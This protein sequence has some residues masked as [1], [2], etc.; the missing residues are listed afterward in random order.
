MSSPAANT[1]RIEPSMTGRD[2]PFMV[3]SALEITQILHAIMRDGSLIT[4]TIDAND[5]FLTS[6]LAIDEA[7]N[8]MYL[9]R[10]RTRPRL[11]STLQ[12]RM[13]SYN[14]TLEKVQ[15]RFSSEGIETAEYDGEEAYKVPLPTEMLR[16]QR[17]EFYRVS[18]P[19]ANPV[20]CRLS[21]GKNAVDGAVELNICDISCGGIAVQSPPALFT[22]ELGAYYECVVLLPGTPG[23]HIKVQ[24]RNAFMMTMLNGK[25]AQRC[26]FAF[27]NPSESMVATVQRY[28]LNLERQQRARER[29]D[30]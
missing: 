28:I 14:T 29:R 8:C 30:G 26:G 7:E 24:A 25:I 22:P 19:K 5:F 12:G 20:K 3:S 2:N 17:R 6:L 9:E 13:L 11:S 15:I 21:A 23:L 16:M 27:V 18:T 4:V 1:A 10:S